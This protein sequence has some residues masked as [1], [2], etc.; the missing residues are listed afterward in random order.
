MNQI[1]AVWPHWIVV[2][3]FQTD[4]SNS[5]SGVQNILRRFHVYGDIDTYTVGSGNWIFIR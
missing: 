2:F 3:G 1:E 5:S 4:V